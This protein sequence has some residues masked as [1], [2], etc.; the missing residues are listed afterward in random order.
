MRADV[1][2]QEVYVL[3]IYLGVLNCFCV[4]AV[5]KGYEMD[6]YLKLCTSMPPVCVEPRRTASLLALWKAAATVAS[7]QLLAYVG[8]A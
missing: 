6:K 4:L 7:P 1:E 5:E 3:R 8:F 2:P